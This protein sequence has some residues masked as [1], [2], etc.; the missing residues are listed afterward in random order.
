VIKTICDDNTDDV[1]KTA[2]LYIINMYC[3]IYL[4]FRLKECKEG[5]RDDTLNHTTIDTQDC[6]QV[7]LARW[8][9]CIIIFHCN[10]KEV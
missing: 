10:G 2:R 6:D 5:S 1:R 9:A 8:W 3:R 7:S 4:K